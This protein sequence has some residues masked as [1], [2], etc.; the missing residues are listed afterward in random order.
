MIKLIHIKSFE[1]S[2]KKYINETLLNDKFL[3]LYIY[4]KIENII[5]FPINYKRDI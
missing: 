3:F 5:S 1:I 4:T 2:I